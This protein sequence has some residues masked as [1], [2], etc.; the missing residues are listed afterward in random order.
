MLPVQKQTAV[1]VN[2]KSKQLLLFA[3]SLHVASHKS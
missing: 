2:L 1:T 3:F